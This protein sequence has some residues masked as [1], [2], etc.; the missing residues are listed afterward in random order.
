MLF[1]LGNVHSGKSLGSVCE[2]EK[3]ACDFVYALIRAL[4]GQ[5]HRNKQFKRRCVVKF[6]L[7][8]RVHT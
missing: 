5:N 8:I 2:F 1:K 6:A 7:R 3:L 4:S